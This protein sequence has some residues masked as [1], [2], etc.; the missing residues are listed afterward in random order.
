MGNDVGSDP[1][2][3]RDKLSE[4]IREAAFEIHVVRVNPA[5]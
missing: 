1:Y 3:R 4:R 5:F 2:C